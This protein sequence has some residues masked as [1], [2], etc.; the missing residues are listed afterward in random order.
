[1]KHS[2]APHWLVWLP[3]VSLALAVLGQIY[4]SGIWRGTVDAK[5]TEDRHLLDVISGQISDLYKYLPAPG[6]GGH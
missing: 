6:G 1:M 5:L 3:L 4:T 2:G